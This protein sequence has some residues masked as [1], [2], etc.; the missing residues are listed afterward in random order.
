MIDSDKREFQEMLNSLL[1]L[2]LGRSPKEISKEMI[3]MY[4]GALEHRSLDDVRLALNKHVQDTERGRW[5]PLPADITAQLSAGIDLWPAAD[6]AWA[7]AP[8]CDSESAPMFPEMA[9]ALNVAAHLIEEGDMVAARM[10]FKAA[11]DRSVAPAKASGERPKWYTSLGHDI[12]GRH[13]ASVRT[14][15]LKNLGRDSADQLALPKPKSEELGIFM[16]EDANATGDK[17]KALEAVVKM[18]GIINNG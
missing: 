8:K 18:K 5:F 7:L 15:E 12:E 4:W 17:K 2:P 10:A 9:K 14:V 11:Y 6:E 1:A 3:R 16:I 13:D